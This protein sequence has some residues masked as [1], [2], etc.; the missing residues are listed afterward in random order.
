[1]KL[2]LAIV[3]TAFVLV[4]AALIPT[5]DEASDAMRDASWN[6]ASDLARFFGPYDPDTAVDGAAPGSPP[7]L[8]PT[9][10]DITEYPDRI[11]KGKDFVVGGTVFGTNGDPVPNARVEAYLNETKTTPGFLAGVGRT[12]EKGEYAVKARVPTALIAR[13]YQL[14]TRHTG[15][16]AGPYFFLESYSDPDVRVVSDTRLRLDVPDRDLVAS[17]TALRGYLVDAD[18][19]AVPGHPVTLKIDDEPVNATQTGPDGSFAFTQY[20][21]TPGEH[22]VKIE[23][24]GTDWYRKSDATGK[25]MIVGDGFDLPAVVHVERGEPWKIEGRLLNE[26]GPEPD[27]KVVIDL[28]DLGVR[29]GG[30]DASGLTTTTDAQGHFE[31]LVDIAPGVRGGPHNVTYRSGDREKTQVAVVFIPTHLEVTGFPVG[32]VTREGFNGTVRLTDN[33][34]APL[35]NATVVTRFGDRSTSLATDADGKAEFVTGEIPPGDGTFVV[36]FP[37]NGWHKGTTEMFPYTVPVEP[38]LAAWI[39]VVAALVLFASMAGAAYVFLAKRRRARSPLVVTLSIVETPAGAPDV[40]EPKEKFTLRVNARLKT[41]EGERKSFPDATFTLDAGTERGTIRTDATGEVKVPLTFTEE[42]DHSVVVRFPGR[43]GIPRQE[44][45]LKVRLIPYRR[46]IEEAYADLVDRA[47][48]LGLGVDATTTPRELERAVL[49]TARALEPREV[50]ALLR[51]FEIADY[52][53]HAIDRASWRAFVQ[54]ERV[55]LSALKTAMGPAEVP[56]RA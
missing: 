25:I 44:F 35:A 3:A 23:F 43:P 28:R 13:D 46:A 4:T 12:N 21:E 30:K 17:P 5:V 20:F 50:D 52:S 10:T 39:W 41:P 6:L 8:M 51:L 7:R 40:F 16:L 18:G 37:G 22:V 48:A 55:A 15:T 19:A 38:G 32:N 56:V 26:K 9:V 14:V 47:R 34:G 11:D 33:L 42:G 2:E 36:A 29:F 27:A 49:A 45:E 1:M 31:A 54:G 53:E 24:D